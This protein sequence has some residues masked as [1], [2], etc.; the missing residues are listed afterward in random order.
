MI[1]RIVAFA[2]AGALSAGGALAAGDYP[3]DQFE[4]ITQCMSDPSCKVEKEDR[5]TGSVADEQSLT[6]QRPICIGGCVM[7]C[8]A[9]ACWCEVDDRCNR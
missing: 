4:R 9:D 5:I 2:V 7:V 6:Y 1:A 8:T 3:I